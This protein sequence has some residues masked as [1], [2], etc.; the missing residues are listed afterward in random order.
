MKRPLVLV[1]LLY[2]AGVL[3]GEFLP[4]P[5]C[6]LL[7]AS[8]A[9]ALAALAWG[10]ARARLLYPL[11]LLAA[12]T[13]VVL[14]TAIISP[15][16]VRQVLSEQ[17]EIV[18]VRGRLR[19]TP[20]VH[21]HD[22]NG[23][24][25]WRTLAQ[26]QVAGLQPNHK[27]WQPATGRMMVST[28]GMLTNLFGGQTVEVTGVAAP[29][30]FAA[31]PGLFDYRAY[32]RRLGIYYELAASSQQDWRIL[33]S[34]ARPP[35]AD[36]FR[37]WA[38]RALALGLPRGEDES[39]R[40]E[41]AL[42]LGDKAVLTEEVAEPFVRAA[43]YH[44]FAV[45]GLR[46]AILFG[47]FL[48]LLRV[49]G[50]S[51]A[52]CG[53]VL[54]PL[55]WSY[56]A[57]TGW[58]ASAIRATVMLSVVIIGWALKRPSNMI[59]S[60]FAAALIILVWEPRQLFQAGFQLSFFVVLCLVLIVPVA[61][62]LGGR[63]F[64]PDPLLA[65][66][67]RARWPG[68][69]RVP[70]R[71][72]W[73]VLLTS[74]AAWIGALPL[75]AYY[76]NIVTPVSTPANLAAVPL[77]ALVLVSNLASLLLAGWFPGAAEIFNHAGW[78]LMECIRV[79]SE[80][81]AAWPRAYFYVSAPGFFTSALYYAVLLGSVTGWLFKPKWRGWKMAALGIAALAWGWQGW[82]EHSLA[83]VSILPLNGGTAIYVDAPG[84][85]DGFLVNC[86]PAQAAGSTLKPFLR[87]QGVNRLGRLVLTHGE[88]RE[89]GGAELIASLFRVREVAAS[90]VHFR[91]PQYRQALDEFS[92]APGLLRRVSRNER[93]GPGMV[94]HPGADEHFALADDNA[95]V[96]A[97]TFWRTRVLLLSDLGRPGQEVLR[98]RTPDLKADIV[99]T[100]IPS[101]SGSEALGDDLLGAIQPRLI[102]VTDSEYP[103]SARANA[104]LR[105][106]LE[107]RG[108][109]VFY[110]RSA[111]AVTIE[112][113]KGGWE[114]KAMSGMTF[115]GE[116]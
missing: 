33:S 14:Q 89:T 81:F 50:L 34:P 51:R 69:V 52:V 112:I 54:I 48:A 35:M 92:R 99:V 102:I 45:D 44:I 22:N 115:H 39:L 13:N 11:V 73:D 91:S 78:F 93:L 24:M 8:L 6:L 29:P 84:T 30:K 5:P 62:R 80:W 71:F 60:L 15:H 17:P 94:L 101:G 96:L 12:W 79:S 9:V 110:T 10:K 31:A 76:F 40:L 55:I 53:L 107:Q 87:A 26:L 90:P 32:L 72:L 105:E 41:W 56:V 7:F 67:L 63:L 4:L 20:V 68:F 23:R 103:A 61:H 86:G 49:F 70:A 64:A 16:D 57:L 37:A 114:V 3:A 38:R 58:P 98:E 36:R 27:G 104:K 19:E 42:T 88:L 106:R 1:G 109:P 97:A 43:T 65:P 113:R 77:C 25:T 59:N 66:H 28:P 111:G 95:V 2:I 75:V 21:T 108:I 85:R 46:M 100:G 47:I 116:N 82:Q 18:T 74:L 83:R